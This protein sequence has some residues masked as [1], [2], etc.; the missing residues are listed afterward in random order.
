MM[1]SLLPQSAKMSRTRCNW[2][3]VWVAMYEVLNK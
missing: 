2:S 3:L 1:P